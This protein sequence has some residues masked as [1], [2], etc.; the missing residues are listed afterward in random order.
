M[1]YTLRYRPG[2]KDE[3]IKFLKHDL[4]GIEQLTK[5]IEYL[6]EHPEMGKPPNR[7]KGK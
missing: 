3:I 5:K 2:L 6:T 7:L 1:T 4:L